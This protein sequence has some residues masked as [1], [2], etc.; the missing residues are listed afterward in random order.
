MLGSGAE[1]WATVCMGSMCKIL[2]NQIGL[3]HRLLIRNQPIFIL[4]I[5]VQEDRSFMVTKLQGSAILSESVRNCDTKGPGIG[6]GIEFYTS[7]GLSISLGI[8]FSIFGYPTQ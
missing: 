1:N 8:E 7:L 2:K 5:L 4:C 3:D 6:I